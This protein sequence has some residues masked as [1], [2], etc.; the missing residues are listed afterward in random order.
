MCGSKYFDVIVRGI[1]AIVIFVTD[2]GRLDRD[3]DLIDRLKEKV[4]G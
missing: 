1:S 3:F 4:R 2:A